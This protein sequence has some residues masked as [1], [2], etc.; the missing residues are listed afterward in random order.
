[1]LFT[2]FKEQFEKYKLTHNAYIESIEA[3]EGKLNWIIP[4]QEKYLMRIQK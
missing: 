3:D 1:M 4:I 2:E